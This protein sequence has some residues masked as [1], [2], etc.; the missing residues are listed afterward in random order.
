MSKNFQIVGAGSIG[1]LVAG[2][3]ASR[4]KT[5]EI[6]ESS[7][8]FG[9][10]TRDILTPDGDVFFSGCQYLHLNYL[11][12][13]LTQRLN[14]YEFNHYY[15][16][17]TEENGIWNYKNLFAGPVFRH[18]SIDENN[19]ENLFGTLQQR[20][21]CYSKP[22]NTFLSNYIKKFFPFGHDNLHWSGSIAL[23]IS[24]IGTTEND[25]ELLN[26]K[27]R[28]EIIDSLY[29]VGHNV[30]GI[31][32]ERAVLPKLGFSKFWN[33]Y[34][35]EINNLNSIKINLNSKIKS[36]NI[37][38]HDANSRKVWCADPRQMVAFAGNSKLD[39][40]RYKIISYGLNLD[41][42][43]GPQLPFYINVFSENHPFLRLF[44]YE[45]DSSLKISVDSMKEFQEISE[46]ETEILFLADRANITIKVSKKNLA[47]KKFLRFFPISESDYFKISDSE[48]QLSK[49]NWI[50]GGTNLYDRKSRMTLILNQI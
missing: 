45:I 8:E 34:S 20:L 30:R 29:G 40:L 5:V 35:R 33:D 41:L 17:L 46:L 7:K 25:L 31:A 38:F 37:T 39:S 11:P 6:F 50:R 13:S 44:F 15:A 2:H 49:L 23:G 16:S 22:I 4:Y 32:F 10:I 43:T 47:S 19:C 1:L 28:S 9:G 21:A 14:L 18:E 26:I 36:P 12:V 3:V 42:Y 48:E 24:R 27:N